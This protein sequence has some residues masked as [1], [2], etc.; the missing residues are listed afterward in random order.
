MSAFSSDEKAAIR[1][2]W[3]EEGASLTQIAER[4][5]VSRSRIGAWVQR[6][7]GSGTGARRQGQ[8]MG[9]RPAEARAEPKP[10]PAPKPKPT[11]RAPWLTRSPEPSPEA[12]AVIPLTVAGERF[13][14][15]PVMPDSRRLADLPRHRCRWPVGVATSSDQ[16][17]CGEPTAEEGA[18][19]C[20]GHKR[21]AATAPYAR[22]ERAA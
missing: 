10:K 22:R 13:T 20:A 11:V 15:W 16:L 7:I 21:V 3:V 17:F 5:G 8:K 18:V 2:M 9:W 14:V 12:P 4:L 19:Y 6:N 1:R